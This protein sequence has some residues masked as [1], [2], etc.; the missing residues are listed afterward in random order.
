[1]TINDT[2][3][4]S[5]VRLRPAQ[6]TDINAVADLTLA[7]CSADG[8]PL[9]ATSVEDFQRYWSEPGFNLETESW[10]AETP[11]GR[12]VGYE[13]LYDR[14]AHAA[15]EGDGYV[16]PDFIGQG[17]GTSLL[18]ALEARALELM[19]QAEP[20]LRVFLRN[21]MCITDK[22]ARGL[23]ENE[24]YHPIRFSWR[25]EIALEALPPTPQWPDGIE[26]RPFIVEDHAHI[27]HEAVE[28]AFRDHWG[29]TPMPFENW[30]N[31]TLLRESFDPSLWMIAWDGDEIAGVS[32][33]RI[34]SE[35]GWVGSLGVR[36][37]WRKQG[38]GLALLQ[39]SFSEF[40]KRGI[41][42]IGLG[43]DADNPTGATRLYQR[44]GMKVAS[45]YVFY[46][47]ELRP[48][49]SVEDAEVE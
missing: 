15:L 24:G 12:I 8:D 29:H 39:Q 22:P 34:R 32:L 26:L 41:K 9:V 13:E 36:R 21:G 5:T 4:L 10:V 6:W 17:I 45:E 3:T 48:G 27:V 2:H 19:E 38:L 30:K 20:D 33:N 44:A 7:V 35:L 43:V 46:E 23:H 47:K 31:Y 28:E 25:M 14:H 16:H 18:T 42:F 1:M 49:R 11:D 37:P 40:Y